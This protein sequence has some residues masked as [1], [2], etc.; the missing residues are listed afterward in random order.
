MR[1]TCDFVG[2]L[3]A[4]RDG[5]WKIEDE[6]GEEKAWD[7][8]VKLRERMFW[9]RLGTQSWNPQNGKSQEEERTSIETGGSGMETLTKA[10]VNVE[11][12]TPELQI[13]KTFEE[14]KM[15]NDEIATYELKIQNDAQPTS[16]P[17][18]PGHSGTQTPEFVDAQEPEDKQPEKEAEEKPDETGDEVQNAEGA[19]TEH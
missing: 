18:S 2:F 13:T 4:V 8:S 16:E 10:G 9:A 5:I 11:P 15:H 1:V 12:V 14:M 19:V 7:E 3:R 6:E 17:Q